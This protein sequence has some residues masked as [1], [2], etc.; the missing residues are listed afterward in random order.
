VALAVSS[1]PAAAVTCNVPS[2]PYPTIAGALAD[3]TCTTVQVAA[4][5]YTESLQVTRDVTVQGAG[6]ASTVVAGV[7]RASGPGVDVTL[8]TLR[9]DATAA[10]TTSCAASALGAPGRRGHPR[11]GPRRPRSRHAH[12]ELRPHERRLRVG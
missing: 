11:P 12:R 1:T 4:G 3:P 10:T 5:T 8:R 7:L 2:G 6:S 9:I